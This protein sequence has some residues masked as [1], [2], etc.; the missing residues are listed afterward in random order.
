MKLKQGFKSRIKELSKDKRDYKRFLSIIKQ[1]PPKAI[2][3]NTLKIKPKKLKERL[4]GKG[5]KIKQIDKETFKIRNNLNPGELGKS[6]EHLLG[7]YY[8][9]SVVSQ[10]PIKALNPKP[11]ELVLDLAAAPGSKTTHCCQYME[12]KGTIIANDKD[13]FRTKNMGFNLDRCG[14][15]NVIAT[16]HNGTDLNK[17]L[18][19][20]GVKFDKIILDMP[21]SAEGT[22]RSKPEILEKWNE[23]KIDKFNRM[24]TRLAESA[25]DLLKSSGSLIYSTCT[26][27]PEENEK[28]VSNLIDNFDLEIEKISLP[29]KTREGIT[30]WEGQKYNKEV[31][32]ATRVYPQDNNTEGFFLAKLKKNVT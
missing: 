2:R 28:V 4:E 6:R 15:M 30:E 18:R 13:G 1:K 25:I 23:D 19:K 31:K 20:I 9:Q 27:A 29:L 12:N 16:N 3:C 7:Y 10:L 22:S 11:G 14:C 26:F 24:Q 32:K 21:C 8:I 17:K 5:W